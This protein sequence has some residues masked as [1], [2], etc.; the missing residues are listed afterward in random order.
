[1]IYLTI[2]LGLLWFSAFYA[3][4]G[5]FKQCLDTRCIL[6][7][8]DLVLEEVGLYVHGICTLSVRVI[9]SICDDYVTDNFLCY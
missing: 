9:Y 3:L 8:L 2:S 6:L 1:M 4:M 5:N 7:I